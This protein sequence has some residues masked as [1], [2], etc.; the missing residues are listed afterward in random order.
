M[1][2]VIEDDRQGFDVVELAGRKTLNGRVG[3]LGMRERITL[4]GGELRVQS[5]P[6]QGTRLSIEIPLPGRGGS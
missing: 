6:G 5:R 1:F 3:L 4:L 2:A